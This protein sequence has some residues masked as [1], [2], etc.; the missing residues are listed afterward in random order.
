MTNAP[1][2][3]A[4]GLDDMAIFEAAR[5]AITILTIWV[6]IGEAVAR[7]H[8]PFDLLLGRQRLIATL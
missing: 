1:E 6:T 5:G 4:L 3:E 7:A 8:R 2:G